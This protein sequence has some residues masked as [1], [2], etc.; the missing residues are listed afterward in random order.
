MKEHQRTLFDA[1]AVRPKPAPVPYARGSD[2][3]KAAAE[4]TRPHAAEI[5]A[6]VFAYIRDQGERGT[7][8]EEICAALG[9]DRRDS[10][11]PRRVELR[12]SGHI[13]DSG[14]R[15]PTRSG[16][17]AAV[18]VATGKPLDQGAG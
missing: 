14:Q 10:L 6:V 8:D 13:R 2:T 17:S 15:R 16:R 3:S 11:R 12:D 7:T 18:W 5:R 4:A 1:P 9:P